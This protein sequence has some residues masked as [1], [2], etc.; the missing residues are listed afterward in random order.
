[1]NGGRKT[2]KTQKRHSK[3]DIFNLNDDE[4]VLTHG[5]L[6]L[7]ANVDDDLVDDGDDEDGK[8][9]CSNSEQRFFYQIS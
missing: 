1:M 3:R 9:A 4:D 7:S 6:A 2:N 8:P 5:G